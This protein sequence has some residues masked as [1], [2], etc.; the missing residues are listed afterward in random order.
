L[1]PEEQNELD[2]LLIERDP[3]A[4]LL[5]PAFD[6][7]S[8]EYEFSRTDA[9]IPGNLHVKQ[10]KALQSKAKHRWLFWGNQVGKTTLGAVDLALLCLGRHPYLQRWEPP[11]TAWASALTW[12]LW[13]KILLPELLTWIP[14]DRIIDAP[15][16]HQ[17]S[18]KRDILIRAD[19]GKISRITGKAAEQGADKYQSARVHAVWLDEEHPE[20]VWDEMQPR[21][22]RHGGITLATMTPLKGLTW[23]YHRVYEPWKAGTTDPNKHFISHAGLADNPSVK[24]EEIDSLSDELKH[25]PAQLAARLHGHFVRPTGLV[26]PFDTEKHFV[27]VTPNHVTQWLRHGRKKLWAAID[28]G[29][30]RFA[31]GLAVED[32]DGGLVL[33]DEVFSQRESLEQRARKIHNVLTKWGATKEM[34]ITGDCANP[35]DILELSLALTRI[36]SEFQVSGVDAEKK[37][38]K[39]GIER[40]ENLLNRGA[41]RVRRGLGEGHTWFLGFSAAKQGKPIMGSRWLWEINN[42][43]YPND[44]NGK[45]QK[46]NPDD[47]SAD[48]ADMM[49]MTRYMVM[50]WWEQSNHKAPV[51][52]PDE[53]PGFTEDGRAK[54][55]VRREE[56]DQGYTLPQYRMPT[57]GGN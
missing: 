10:E 50:S 42:W 35:Q 56:R 4:K 7:V 5:D 55:T 45:A 37:I 21:L 24:Q 18:T 25:N 2:Q 12:E 17:K 16:P 34:L 33:I 46:D 26:L 43:Q 41:F 29:L 54:D 39:V 36:G 31:F 40:T 51:R 48:G 28:F 23:V 11:I 47:D 1:T 13:E 20:A 19:N 53:H 15:R 6:A 44:D 52:H 14:K 30:W 32:P 27:D 57:Y 22:L 9:E 38:I 49:A 8:W 3:L